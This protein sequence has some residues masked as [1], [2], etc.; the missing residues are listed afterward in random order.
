MSYI[1]IM[2]KQPKYTID[3]HVSHPRDLY[4]C[5]TGHIRE[6]ERIYQEIDVRTG[7]FKEGG[8]STLESTIPHCVLPYTVTAEILTVEFPKS[9]IKLSTG[10]LHENSWT[11]VSKFKGW[12][13]TVESAK[14][15]SVFSER[16]L[17]PL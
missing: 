13:Y 14:M 3:Q 9:V 2:Q 1:C 4:N 12:A 8:L 6:I 10:E 17:K 15:R 7:N 16:S 5:T 11:Q